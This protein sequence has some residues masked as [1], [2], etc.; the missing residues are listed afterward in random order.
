[1]YGE[2]VWGEENRILSEPEFFFFFLNLFFFWGE[3][4]KRREGKGD[5]KAHSWWQIQA[6]K[7]NIQTWGTRKG[8]KVK[9]YLEY[10]VTRIT[11]FN[12]V[13]LKCIIPFYFVLIFFPWSPRLSLPPFEPREAPF[14]PPP[15]PR[16]VV[17][18]FLSLFKFFVHH[19]LLL[20]VLAEPYLD[21]SGIK[22]KWMKEH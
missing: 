14:S 16:E 12:H 8:K 15:P 13:I 9:R 21:L 17:A 22:N 10:S 4:R 19:S 11:Y 18:I 3:G 5:P 6:T 7:C 20:P 2:I 1:M